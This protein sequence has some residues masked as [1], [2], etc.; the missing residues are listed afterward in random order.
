MYGV[1]KERV[2]V[3]L[4]RR[5]RLLLEGMFWLLVI[6]AA[7]ARQVVPRHIL[8]CARQLARGIVHREGVQSTARYV[9]KFPLP[10]ACEL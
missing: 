8:Q 1:P 10:V 6:G 7:A 5:R 4:V 3:H 9:R 2:P